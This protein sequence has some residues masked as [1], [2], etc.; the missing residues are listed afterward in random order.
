MLKLVETLATKAERAKATTV[1]FSPLR[2]AHP[3]TCD[4]CDKFAANPKAGRATRRSKVPNKAT[5]K[6]LGTF[7][8]TWNAELAFRPDIAPP[9][10][11]ALHP[12][13][14]LRRAVVA[15]G[16][17]PDPDAQ[18][19]PAA[20]GPLIPP[21]AHAG[22]PN[23]GPRAVRRVAPRNGGVEA[24][25]PHVVID[26]LDPAIRARLPLAKIRGVL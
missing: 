9:R 3:R 1:E 20:D 2:G 12:S 7:A 18:R 13:S 10:V 6:S 17:L 16:T 5:S 19:P 26:G 21:R 14:R 4:W 22:A 24:R 23:R 25:A 15:A 8:R 11:S